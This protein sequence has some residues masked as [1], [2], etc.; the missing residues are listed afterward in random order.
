MKACILEPL[1]TEVE[2]DLRLSSHLH[3][4]LTTATLSRCVCVRVCVCVCVCVCGSVSEKIRSK[5]LFERYIYN[6]CMKT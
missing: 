2:K 4:Q 1:C 5:I 6:L 3:L